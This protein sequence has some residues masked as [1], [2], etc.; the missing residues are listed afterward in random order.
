MIITE[1]E[2]EGD[3]CINCVD[4]EA[5]GY[6]VLEEIELQLGNMTYNTR[7]WVCE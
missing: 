4:F 2:G 1:G 5:A 3:A 7:L 6:Y